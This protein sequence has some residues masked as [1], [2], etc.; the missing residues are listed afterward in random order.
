MYLPSRPGSI[1]AMHIA[2]VTTY[3]PGTGSLN[4]YAF[5]FVRHLRA[6]PEVRAITLLVDD[7]PEGQGYPDEPPAPGLAPVDIVPCWRFGALGNALRLRAAVK[8]A[9]PDAVLFNIQFASFGRGKLSGGLGLL[10]PAMVRAMGLPTIVLLHNI[11]ETVDLKQAGFAGNPLMARL[12]QLAGTA[13]TRALLQADLVALTIPKYVELLEAKYRAGN[14]VLA[15]HGAFDDTPRPI[16]DPP[17]NPLQI[18][19]FGKF[20]T[21]K[22]VEPLVEAFRALP[23]PGRPPLELVIAGTD[24]PNA[25]GY[26]EGIRRRYADVPGIRFT[27]YVA[28]EDVPRIFNQAAMLVLPYTSTTGS[29]GVLHQAGDYGRAVVLPNVGDLA[30]LI[31]EEGY[32]GEFFEPGDD[33]S[34][35]AAIARLID[36]PQRR[37]DIGTRNYLAA[38]GLPMAEVVDWYILHFQGLIGARPMV[39]A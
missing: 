13:L 31:A 18:M 3:P 23:A 17:E 7:L 9:A 8:D 11:V 22:R 24:S 14:V 20:G 5:H 10:A 37:R 36:D 26:L 25:P 4:E 33:A 30:E 27:G 21:Y 15:P 29:S 16:T 2:I 28:E 38:R 1:L 34:L 6:K 12:I 19:T 32:A 39:M 35:A